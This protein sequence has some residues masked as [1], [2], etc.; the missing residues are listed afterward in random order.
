MKICRIIY[1]WPPPWNGLAPHPYELTVSQVALGHQVHVFC[2]RWPSAGHIESPKGVTTHPV[3][4]E[5]FQ[6]TI[7]VTSSIALLFKYLSWRRKNKD[8][9][10][11]HSHGHFGM[12]VYG[13]RLFLQKFFPWAEELKTPL[14]VHFHNTVKG[15][16]V[17]MEEEGKFIMP[18]S[19]FV[20]WPLAVIS[21]KW[22]LKTAAACIFVSKDT[23]EEANKYYE[24]DSRRCFVVESGVNPARFIRVGEEERTKSRSDLGFDVYDKVILNYGMFVER[25][26]IHALVES[27]VH[28]PIQYKLLLVGQWPNRDYSDRVDEIIKTKNLASRVVKIGYT[29][30]PNIPIALQNADLMVLPSS[31]EG[32]PKVVVES[33]CVGLP[34]LVSGFTMK[35]DVKGVFYLPSIEPKD[36]A[37]NIVKILSQKQQVDASKV[38]HE[39][40]W[41]RRAKEVEGVYDFAKK[42]YLA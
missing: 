39:Y 9:D 2:G 31:W 5:P 35:E 30:Y 8:V 23:A 24:M 32:L 6:G 28:L 19:R 3:L 16:W 21:D 25:K 40:S 14:V 12:W 1:D 33:L 42:N 13:Y 22:A 29:P 4:R 7:A 15:R 27:L 11:I 41:E 37:D 20:A 36:I 18:H 17:K 10:I 34:C 38:I 26:N